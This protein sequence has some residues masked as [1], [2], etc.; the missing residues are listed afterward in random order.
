M[1]ARGRVL[2]RRVDSRGARLGRVAGGE[3]DQ[4][5]EMTS[6]ETTAD[7]ALGVE[8]PAASRAR[9]RSRRRMWRTIGLALVWAFVIGNGVAIVYLWIHG[10]RLSGD[11]SFDSQT[12]V[13]LSLARITGLLGAYLALIEVALLARLPWLERMVRF[14]KLTNSPR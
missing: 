13:V 2:L 4:V 7:A 5:G 6:A 11:L 12:Q 10:G 3:G 1:P 8:S 14:D 9:A